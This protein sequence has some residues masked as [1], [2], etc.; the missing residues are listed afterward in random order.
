LTLLLLILP[1]LFPDP[2]Q[3]L[4][5]AQLPHVSLVQHEQVLNYQWI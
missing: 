2:V 5:L 3:P 4:F 1:G